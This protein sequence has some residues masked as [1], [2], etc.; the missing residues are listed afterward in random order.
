MTSSRNCWAVWS[1]DLDS[2]CNAITDAA[3]LYRENE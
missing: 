3:A 2:P 1:N